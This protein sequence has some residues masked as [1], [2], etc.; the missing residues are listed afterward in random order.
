MNMRVQAHY[1]IVM[2]PMLDRWST[3]EVAPET[4]AGG[5]LRSCVEPDRIFGRCLQAQSGDPIGESTY[6]P[7]GWARS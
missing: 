1:C 2:Q 5:S 6:Y 3:T 7:F 4:V